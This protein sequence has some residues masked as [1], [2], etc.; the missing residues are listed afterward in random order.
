MIKKLRR[1]F[2][3]ITMISVA[4]VLTLIIGVID[5]SD[6]RNI[7]QTIDDRMDLLI[8]NGGSVD[9][10][11]AD[12][13]SPDNGT[14][15]G[16]SASNGSSDDA[17]MPKAP[18]SDASVE[19]VPQ[20]S[21]DAMPW[22]ISGINAETKFDIRYFTVTLDENGNTVDVDTDR[23]ASIGKQQ[24]ET[25]A[26]DLREEGKTEGYTDGFRYAVIS[27]SGEDGGNNTMYIFLNCARELSTFRSFLWTSIL[28]SLLGAGLVFLLVVVASRIAVRPVAESYEKQK[29]FITDASHEIKTPL[30]IIEA[31]TE[32]IELENGSSEWL[33]SIKRQIKRLSSLTEK[34]V[35]LSRMDEE[36]TKI[37]RAEFSLSDTVRETTESFEAVAEAGRKHLEID[38]QPGI[39]Y[40]GNEGMISQMVSLLV[41]N[42][43][44]YGSDGGTVRVRLWQKHGGARVLTVYNDAD[45]VTV[46]DQSQLFERFYRSDE[47]RN[48]RTGGHG[49]GLSVVKAIVDAHH[50]KIA[51]VS[52]DGKSMLFTV[53]L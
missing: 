9:D 32:V 48:S 4:I 26:Q 27:V 53:R 29:R 40:Y 50:G 19:K 16:S 34:L 14:A 36:N 6:Y 46:G 33:D 42:A 8:E 5:V 39:P 7:S 13:G 37:E 12:N 1:K 49:I 51:A 24:A 45:H 47:S 44:K 18:P 2:I 10:G 30:A 41:D 22:N 28:V 35:F 25:M 38:V 23:I 20:D 31:N 15:N 21:G 3:A 17:D 52:G 11:S 43:M